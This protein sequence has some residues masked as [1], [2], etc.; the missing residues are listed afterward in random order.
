MH[1]LKSYTQPLKR[2][3]T[4]K[5]FWVGFT[6]WYA[7]RCTPEGASR[8]R[9]KPRANRS[10]QTMLL[11]GLLVG[12]PVIAALI[13]PMAAGTMS[14]VGTRAVAAGTQVLSVI[15]GLGFFIGLP[16]WAG[17]RTYKFCRSMCD[18]GHDILDGRRVR[19]RLL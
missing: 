3:C 1:T 15:I 11:V 13:G 9:D 2:R 18:R 14:A 5:S 4:F 19:V 7:E 16:A 12:A 6:D 17:Y 10:L 8:E